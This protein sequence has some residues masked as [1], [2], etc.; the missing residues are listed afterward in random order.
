MTTWSRLAV[1]ERMRIR[2]LQTFNALD[3]AIRFG[4]WFLWLP[5]MCLLVALTG[6]LIYDIFSVA[7]QWWFTV[8]AMVLVIGAA[9]RRRAEGRKGF[10]GSCVLDEFHRAKVRP[11]P[12]SLDETKRQMTP[13][14]TDSVLP[15][16]ERCPCCGR[17]LVY[18]ESGARRI[19]CTTPRGVGAA[20]GDSPLYRECRS[21]G[22]RWHRHRRAADFAPPRIVRDQWTASGRRRTEDPRCRGGTG[23]SKL[24]AVGRRSNGV[25]ART[26]N[27]KGLRQRGVR[28]DCLES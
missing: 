7:L 12:A 27:D 24:A 13:K 25:R 16:L 18:I 28:R 8:P 22:A 5:G 19:S 9:F 11:R 4:W 2:R 3:R 1:E 10:A 15:H 14:Q 6:V 17:G 26:F 23:C 20:L 21:C